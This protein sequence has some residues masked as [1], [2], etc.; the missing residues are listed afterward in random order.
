[1]F[2]QVLNEPL[3]LTLFQYVASIVLLIKCLTHF[4]LIFITN[5]HF[6]FFSVVLLTL[7]GVIVCKHSTSTAI[8]SG[9]SSTYSNGS[10]SINQSK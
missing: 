1:M 10:Q 8:R 5:L 2:D 6:S 4:D 9:S 7:T 3:S